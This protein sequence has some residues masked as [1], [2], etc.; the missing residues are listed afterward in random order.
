M[1]ARV[2]DFDAE[3]PD[4]L[5]WD[6]SFLVHATYPGGRYHQQ[7]YAFLDRLSDVEQTLS[8]VSTL[9][10]DETVFTLIQ[11]KLAE[12]HPERAF[13]EVY[14]EDP[15]AIRPYLSELR[16]LVERLSDD[17][18]VQIVGQLSGS[19]LS[20]LGYME[21][22]PLLPRD[23]LHLTIMAQ[24]GVDCVVTSDADFLPVDDLRIYTCNPRILAR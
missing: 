5:Y 21:D 24:H 1:P 16:T 20:A 6:A 11:L 22:Y 10:L 23:A 14:R 17:P 19:M 12:D 3:L 15:Q 13:W 4:K 8:Y 7:C 9:A 18:R 2:F